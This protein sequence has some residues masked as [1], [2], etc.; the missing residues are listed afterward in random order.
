[1]LKLCIREYIATI[2][3]LKLGNKV[4]S[5]LFSFAA[6]LQLIKLVLSA[7]FDILEREE[8]SDGLKTRKR[9]GIMVNILLINIIKLIL[10][11]KKYYL[12]IFGGI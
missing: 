2:Y 3:N 10:K 6:L 5:T 8:N 9:R 7:H 1:M 12:I 4:L 11:F